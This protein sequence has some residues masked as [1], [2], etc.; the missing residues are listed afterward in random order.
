MYKVGEAVAL[1]AA[2]GPCLLPLIPAIFGY[3]TGTALGPSGSAEQAGTST[4]DTS[5]A[6]VDARSVTV[7][8]L[9]LTLTFILGLATTSAAIG[10]VAAALGQAILIGSWANWVVA[11]ISLVMGLHLLGV[12]DLRMPQS[13]RLMSRRPKRRGYVGAL[14]F[15]GLFGLIVT[16]CATPVLAVIATLAAASGDIPTGTAL[17]FVYG[18]G[19]GFP[20]L[21]VAL[22]SGAIAGMR[23]FSN[24]TV[25]LS[26]AGGAALIGVAIYLVWVA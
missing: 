3:I 21:L 26:R 23:T 20:L 24:A 22:F 2:F 25:W 17:L 19:R 8:S 13:N 16:P 14:L 4:G 18:V 12:I 7:R 15:G 9:T 10:A 5:A 1:R 11:A 6:P